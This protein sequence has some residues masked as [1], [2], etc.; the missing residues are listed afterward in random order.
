[1]EEALKLASADEDMKKEEEEEESQITVEPECFVPLLWLAKELAA[2]PLVEDF[3]ELQFADV[4]TFAYNTN[5][6]GVN[7]VWRKC[8]GVVFRLKQDLFDYAFRIRA[9][10]SAASSPAH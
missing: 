5:T 9:L 4:R 2:L 6:E 10:T 7:N 3:K 1:M 8:I